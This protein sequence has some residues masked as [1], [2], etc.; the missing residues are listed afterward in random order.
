MRKIFG[1]L[2]NSLTGQVSREL[3]ISEGS[4]VTRSQTAK[5]ETIHHRDQCQTALPSAEEALTHPPTAENGGARCQG[6]GS[7]VRPQGED[8]YGL[9]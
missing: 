3:Q 7:S 2:G 5:T 8:W 4:A 6:S 1:T 9:P